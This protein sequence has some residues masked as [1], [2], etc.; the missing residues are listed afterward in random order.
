MKCLRLWTEHKSR[1]KS[2]ILNEFL[3]IQTWKDADADLLIKQSQTTQESILS[4]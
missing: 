4:T 3:T 1:N 2:V